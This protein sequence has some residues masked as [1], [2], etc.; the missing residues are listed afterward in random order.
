MRIE[1]VFKSIANKFV[2]I[3]IVLALFSCVKNNESVTNNKFHEYIKN[4]GTNINILYSI[5]DSKYIAPDFETFD[6]SSE[7]KTNLIRF[8]EVF[9][10]SDK[11]IK[12][13]N[14]DNLINDGIK[15]IDLLRVDIFGWLDREDYGIYCMFY[16]KDKISDHSQ[17]DETKN[18]WRTYN[19]ALYKFR[20]DELEFTG[21]FF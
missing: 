16:S 15:T 19:I 8:L 6:L 13:I 17:F 9:K 21:F 10:S 11:Y 7:Q 14:Y 3:I 1:G 2:I 20:N 5:D 18:L 4:N 12:N